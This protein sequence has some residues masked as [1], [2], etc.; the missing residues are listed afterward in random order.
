MNPVTNGSKFWVQLRQAAVIVNGG[1]MIFAGVNLYRGNDK[2]YEE[3]AMPMFRMF[4]AET[5]HNLGIKLAKYKIVPKPQKPD[6][7]LLKTEVWG[8][9]FPNPIGLAAGYDK[10]GEA[11]DGLLKIGFGFVEV[12]SVTPAPQPGNPTPRVFRLKED[13]AVINRY[14]FNSDGHEV[15]FERLSRRNQE[16]AGES[17]PPTYVGEQRNMLNV[18]FWTEVEDERNNIASWIKVLK[19]RVR[20]RMKEAG[21]LGVNLGKNKTSPDAVSDYVKG[22]RKFG[23][24]ADYLVIN[25]SSPNTPGLRDMQKQEV[26]IELLDQVVAERNKL[27]VSPK[28]PLLVKIAPDLT[29]SDKKDIAA[30]V[31]RPQSG[32]DGLIISN[33]T[34]A[35]PESLKSKHKAEMGGL[36][37]APLTEKSLQ[38]IRDMYR[39]THGKIPIVGVGG[40]SCG[41]DAYD[42]VKAGAS[43]IQMYTALV[44]LGPPAVGKIKREMEELLRKDGY[45]H[46][47]EA[48]GADFKARSEVKS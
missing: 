39:L 14:G 11:V 24:I 13:K 18:N 32:V 25:V 9:S 27:T 8:R 7:P 15:V 43:L 29:E 12:G 19:R 23:G 46:I 36:S 22:V 34:V 44:Y 16:Q 47:S 17:Y 2:F 26:L 10:Q 31:T 42:K 35:R 5:A 45:K 48:V 1:I 41:Q 28:P 37:G 38:V 30:V 40:V 6:S 4:G 3:I 20:T 33:T 21:V